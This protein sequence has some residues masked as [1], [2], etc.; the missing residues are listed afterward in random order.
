VEQEM[1]LNESMIKKLALV[2]VC[3]AMLPIV[4]SATPSP[5]PSV[6]AFSPSFLQT[7]L[8]YLGALNFN[9]G[10]NS[11]SANL[12]RLA[13]ITNTTGLVLCDNHEEL[14]GDPGSFFFHAGEFLVAH[15]GKGAGGTGAGGSLEFFQVT[16]SAFFTLPALGNGPDNPDI[17]GHGGI[18]SIRGFCPP[19]T[20]PDG[21]SAVMLLGL[22]L[23]VVGAIRRWLI[24]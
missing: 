22:G 10:P 12:L 2:A 6:S 20:V 3:A 9:N 14:N 18:S 13:E 1:L 23:G 24:I 21:G 8:T 15:Y 11:P 7:G 16:E 19:G 17:F 5:L 4:V